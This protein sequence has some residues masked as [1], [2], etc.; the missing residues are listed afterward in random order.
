MLLVY[1]PYSVGDIPSGSELLLHPFPLIR[2]AQ[3]FAL[4][5][6]QDG[7]VDLGD[8]FAD[9]GSGNQSVILQG[10]VGLHSGQVSQSYC[11]LQLT[12]NGFLKLLTDF[13]MW[14]CMCSSMRSK[15]LGAS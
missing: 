4:E 2:A 15:R 3:I 11:Q 10:G 9:G 1:S 13:L 8:E 6:S 14:W 5:F 7:P 12:S